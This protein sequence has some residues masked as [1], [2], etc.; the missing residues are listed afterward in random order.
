MVS[1]VSSESDGLGEFGV[2][3]CVFEG[4]RRNDRGLGEREREKRE[5]RDRG[6]GNPGRERECVCVGVTL[7][8]STPHKTH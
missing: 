6:R 5:R 1:L 7:P 4:R 8:L 3:P 2:W